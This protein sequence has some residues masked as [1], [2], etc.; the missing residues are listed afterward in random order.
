MKQN[1]FYYRTKAEGKTGRSTKRSK[2]RNRK[3]EERG[4]ASK[5]AAVP[6]GPG[7]NG[8]TWHGQRKQE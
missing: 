1:Y 3:V 8:F 6:T 5:G 7:Q 2:R 4:R